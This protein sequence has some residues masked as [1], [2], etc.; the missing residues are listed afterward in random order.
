[1][2]PL[3]S[4]VTG[5]YNRPDELRRCIQTVRDQTYRPLQHVIVHDGPNDKIAGLVAEER[6]RGSDVHI[7]FAELGFQTSEFFA[8]SHAA[9]PFMTAQIMA[10]GQYQLWLADDE[11][12]D[13]K[14]IEKLFAMIEA[15]NLDFA[16]SQ[17]W[18][19]FKGHHPEDRWIAGTYPQDGTNC[20]GVLYRRE[21]LDYKM[22]E[23]REGTAHDYNTVM[24]WIKVGAAYNML[25][26][27]TFIH[28]VDV[29]P[30]DNPN[31]FLYRQPLRGNNGHRPYI[32]PRWN[33]FEVDHKGK[34]LVDRPRATLDGK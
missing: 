3:V 34:V 7:K 18:M 6:Y 12:M 4:V 8:Y 25:P 28:R 32:G 27:P 10:E 9:F 29:M 22:F 11:E 17:C 16:Y 21:L 14:H 24:A 15:E 20:T 23:P 13:P 31:K 33:G 5:T 26:E 1:M 19:Y 30:G 2:K